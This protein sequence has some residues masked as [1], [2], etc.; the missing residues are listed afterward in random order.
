MSL[1]V[2]H[3]DR[4]YL[5]VFKHNE[6]NRHLFSD[7]DGGSFGQT[8]RVARVEIWFTDSGDPIGLRSAGLRFVK[9]LTAAE[10]FIP[11]HVVPGF[12]LQVRVLF[13]D[14]IAIIPGAPLAEIEQNTRGP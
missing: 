14:G 1:T 4:D 12:G 3:L 11:N 5:K 7:P 9:F 13:D 6:P 2:E 8:A 10:G